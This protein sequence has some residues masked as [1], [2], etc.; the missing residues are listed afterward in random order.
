MK[1]TLVENSNFV[2]ETVERKPFLLN[3]KNYNKKKKNELH[4]VGFEPTNP[5]DWRLKPARLTTSLNVLPFSLKIRIFT[6]FS[7]RI[8]QY[9]NVVKS[10]AILV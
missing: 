2:C 8:F 5:R 6:N 9:R 10:F 3:N 4:A 7:K 1:K